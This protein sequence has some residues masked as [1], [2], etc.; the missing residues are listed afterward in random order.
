MSNQ[1][2]LRQTLD[3]I[4]RDQFPDGVDRWPRIRDR[5][6]GRM[7]ARPGRP[8][9][10]AGLVAAILMA[11][12]AISTVAYAYFWGWLDQGLQGANES[13][14][15]TTLDQSQRAQG[16]GTP[17]ATLPASWAF[18]P[19]NAPSKTALSPTRERPV[20]AV[21][22]IEGVTVTLNWAYADT[23]RV[24]VGYTISGLDLPE[25]GGGLP[26]V[27]SVSLSDD[28]ETRTEAYAWRGEEWSFNPGSEPGSIEGLYIAYQSLDSV[29]DENLHLHLDIALGGTE[30]FVIPPGVTPT[31]GPIPDE[32]FVSIAPIGTVRF[33]FTVALYRPVILEPMQVVEAAGLSVRLEWVKVNPSYTDLRLCYAMPDSG[34]WQ[35]EATLTMG[36]EPAVSQS[37]TRLE[38]NSPTGNERCIEMSFAVAFGRQ[39]TRM[40][41]AVERLVTTMPEL[42]Q[43]DCDT[44]RRTTQQSGVDFLCQITQGQGGGGAGF[45][46]TRKPEGMSDH[47]AYRIIEDSLREIRPG[48]WAFTIDIP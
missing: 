1:E 7:A 45:L 41:L 3:S 18:G 32:W 46:I 14:L 15:I 34:D 47:E 10:M 28:L 21:Q 26:I 13:G 4:A 30:G 12:L 16:L 40:V 44:G 42:D 23:S 19:T 11:L 39:P 22:S 48:P 36:D 37:A 5:L 20:I 9:R 29:E 6:Q 17:S 27:K 35:P 24:A 38:W 33:D 2:R 43:A 25:V 8:W 31:P